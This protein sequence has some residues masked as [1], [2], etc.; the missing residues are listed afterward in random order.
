MSQRGRGCLEIRPT[1]SAFYRTST[2]EIGDELMRGDDSTV[3]HEK[4][5]C[6]TTSAATQSFT[7]LYTRE[8]DKIGSKV[9]N[10]AL[11]KNLHSSTIAIK[12]RQ[13]RAR[14]LVNEAEMFEINKSVDISAD[15]VLASYKQGTKIEDPRFTT[16]ANEYGKLKYKVCVRKMPPVFVN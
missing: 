5:D 16:T 15:Q 3:S 2:S 13:N 1:T 10:D 11:D 6:Q 12:R 9:R 8:S 7:F 14:M 4:I